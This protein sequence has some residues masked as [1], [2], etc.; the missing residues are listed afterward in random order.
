MVKR[1]RIILM[2]LPFLVLFNLH[3]VGLSAF[4]VLYDFESRKG[5]WLIDSPRVPSSGLPLSRDYAARGGHSLKLSVEFPGKVSVKTLPN[6]DWSRYQKIAFSL[7]LPKGGA[8]GVEVLV[9]LKDGEFWWYQTLCQERL[10]PG[11]WTNIEVDITG[12]S[13]AW[14]GKGH[15]KPWDG[16]VTQ[17]VREFG[18]VLFS[19]SS[20]RGAIYL[21]NVRGEEG[22]KSSSGELSPRLYNFRINSGIIGQYE[23][24]EITF[25][26]SKRPYSNPFDPEAIDIQAHF[27]SPSGKKLTIP[28]FF[29]QGYLRKLEEEKEKLIPIGRSQWK[30]RFAPVE[31]GDYKYY[32]TI[33]DAEG[34]KITTK[35]RAFKVI[36]SDNK[37]FVRVSSKDWHYFEFDNGDFYY[38]IGHSIRAPY[39]ICYARKRTTSVPPYGGTYN[40]DRFFQRMAENKE[41]LVEVWMCPWWLAIEWNAEHGFYHGIGKYNLQNAWKLDYLLDLAEQKGIYI[42]LVIANHGQFSTFVD[43]EWKDNPFNIKN[44]G[45]LRSPEQYFTNARAKQYFRQKMRYIIARWGYSPNMFAWELWSEIDLAGDN[46]RFERSPVKRNWHQEM[47]PFLSAIDPW[48]HL[49]TTHYSTGYWKEDPKVVKLPMIDYTV[50]DGYNVNEARDKNIVQIVNETYNFNK[51]FKKP[52]FITEFGGANRVET[53]EVFEAVLHSGLWATYMTPTAAAP[54]FWWFHFIEDEDMYYHYKALSDFDGGFDRRGKN[55]DI[56]QVIIESQ[57]GELKG[58]CLQNETMALLWIYNPRMPRGL[59]EV[60]AV[61][62]AS[63]RVQKLRKGDYL[64]EFWDTYRGIKMSEGK[65]ASSD[66]T[67]TI[68]LP[69]VLKDIAIKIK[70]ITSNGNQ[71]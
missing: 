47:E 52:T 50:T 71:Y 36:S 55:L 57:N 2:A 29:Y 44:G 34:M 69:D 60:E 62:N 6:A 65:I 59:K 42:H 9:Y 43:P 61:S 51:Q 22:D 40:Y 23:K 56:S 13:N 33:E 4:N 35:M 15:F 67:V 11:R 31:T 24:F 1:A 14:E 12:E 39:D 38:P 19:D 46:P 68:E 18:L 27:I 54:L 49:I 10:K 21:D 64:V 3:P 70:A 20:Y 26:L 37:G 41:N 25:N 66:G 17:R 45:F 28:G 7:F 16:Y 53:K 30:I 5:G 32:I 8:E 58:Q 48:N 63:V